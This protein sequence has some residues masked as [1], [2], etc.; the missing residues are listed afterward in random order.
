M[1]QLSTKSRYAT[2]IMVY[3]AVRYDNG[4]IPAQE[5]AEEESLSVDY[6][7]QILA[8][9]KAAGLVVSR[10]GARGGFR[11]ASAPEK[12]T[13]AD[14]ISAVDGPPMLTPCLSSSCERKPTCA[15]RLVWEEANEALTGVFARKTLRELADSAIQMAQQRIV[16][17]YQI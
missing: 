15:T 1:I 14:I 13:I 16:P 4:A 8:K 11:L 9:L 10:R 6:T 5:I 17:E 7:E 2:R 12:V 3:L